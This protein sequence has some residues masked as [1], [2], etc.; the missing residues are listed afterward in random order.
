[1]VFKDLF[2]SKYTTQVWCNNCQTYQEVQIP[3]GVSIAQFIDGNT[4]KCNNCGCCC[5]VASYK[6]IDE[7]KKQQPKSKIRLLMRK[8]N[9]ET[10]QM[11]PLPQPRPSNRPANLLPRQRPQPSAEPD[12]TPKGVFTNNSNID[13][14][15]G[16]QIKKKGDEDED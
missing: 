11:A 16:R 6:Q 7:F 12:F 14:W 15:T 9:V 3:K 4:G 10:P 5:L 13:F 2:K 1:M 8:Q